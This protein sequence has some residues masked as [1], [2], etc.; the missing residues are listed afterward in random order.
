MARRPI[1]SDPEPPTLPHRVLKNWPER[2]IQLVV[3]SDGERMGNVGD[4]GV[5]V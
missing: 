3:V 5:Q 1:C 4:V 2:R